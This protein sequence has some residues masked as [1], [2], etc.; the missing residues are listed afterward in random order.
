MTRNRLEAF[1]D[2][3]VAIVITIMVLELRVPEEADV[4]GLEPL[5]PVLVAYGL[6]FLTLAIYWNN[7]HHMFQ[8][9]DRVNG[10]IL[11]ANLHLLFWLSLF[12]FVTGWMGETLFEPIPVAAYGV[13]AVLSAVAYYLLQSTIIASQG[14]DSRLAAAVGR[15]AKGKA[16]PIMYIAGIVCTPLNRWIALAFYFAVALMWLIPDR[17][18][19]SRLTAD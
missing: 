19:E 13:V 2:A 7:H 14:S 3:V 1:T 11:W 6:S 18:I 4:H 5:V 8:L 9:T 17:R 16:S 15:D 10:R 12:P